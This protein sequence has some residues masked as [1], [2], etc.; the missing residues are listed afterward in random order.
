MICF[1]L[2]S[3]KLPDV[4]PTSYNR[5]FESMLEKYKKDVQMFFVI[6]P[7]N[8][9]EPYGAIKKRLAVGYGSK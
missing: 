9:T 5:A 7:N 8:K 1:P 4:K 6:L 3:V 2:Y